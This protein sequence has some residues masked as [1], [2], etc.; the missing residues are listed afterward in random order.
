MTVKS[1]KIKVALIY[2]GRSGEHTV[3]CATAAG[4]L[5]ALDFERY[6][7]MPIGITKTGVWVPGTSNKEKLEFNALSE[8]EVLATDSKLWINFDSEANEK[9]WLK[10][11]SGELQEYL[12][13]VDVVFPLLH[14]PYGEDGTIQG[15][16][17]MAN[18]RYVG[19]GVLASAMGMDKH[20]SKV[21][22]QSVGIPVAPWV[23]ITDKTWNCQ[24]GELL[25]QCRSLPLPVFVK[26]SRAGSSLGVSKVNSY[27]QIETAIEEARKHDP[28]VIVEAG[29]SGS[30]VEVGV[31]GSSNNSMPRV[32]V[33]GRIAFE[34]AVEFYDYDT[35]YTDS[36]PLHIEIPANLPVEVSKEI[37]KLAISAF[38]VL[39]C[40][41]LARV[42]FFV[43]ND[44]EVILNE[45]NTMPG[46]TPYSMY[47]QVWQ[48]S[49]VTYSEI[50]DE[51]INLALTRP[52][53]LH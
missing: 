8:T 52:I 11:G 16:F 36:N 2:G 31:L 29:I 15:I 46:F 49:G 45:I 28:R 35:K 50:I 17:E 23:I 44:N 10:V 33:P 13:K 3:S 22:F 27:A 9:Q 4:V 24:K 34:Q 26:P 30:E 51:L 18:V 5:G 14:G 21:M 20:V 37:Q 7:V 48:A 12:A 19:S 32:S 25:E 6:E 39:G 47:P 53:G 41:G 43:T 38:E 1:S 42:D 40:E